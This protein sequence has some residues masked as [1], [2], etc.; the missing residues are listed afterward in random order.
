MAM[1]LKN[2][3]WPWSRSVEKAPVSIPEPDAAVHD[4]AI[5][6]EPLKEI[7][8]GRQAILDEDWAKAAKIWGARALSEP[9]HSRNHRHYIRALIR[10]DR[11][12]EAAAAC[13][14]ARKH[15]R[16]DGEFLLR[17]LWLLDRLGVDD[18]FRKEMQADG[19]AE[20]VAASGRMALI[21]G[22]HFWRRGTLTTARAH[23]LS[24]AA[25]P[26]TQSRAE[27][28]L[29]RLDY[30]AG[31][32]SS[33]KT[34]WTALLND[35]ESRHQPQ[36]PYLF[37]GRIELRNGN[38]EA[39]EELFGIAQ[40]IDPS[41]SA[42]IRKWMPQSAD[43]ALGDL[44]HPQAGEPLPSA[45]TFLLQA[46][47]FAQDPTP[48]I[49]TPRPNEDPD[50]SEVL[51]P[52]PPEP[53]LIDID[54]SIMVA[55]EHLDAQRHDKALDVALGLLDQDDVRPEACEIAGFAA[56]RSG[57]WKNAAFAWGKLAD[58][59]PFRVGALFQAAS[60]CEQLKNR[61]AALEYGERVLRLEPANDKALAFCA[62]QHA[63]SG[64]LAG[65]RA[66]SDRIERLN[67]ENLPDRLAVTLADGFSALGARSEAAT[68][69]DRAMDTDA[70]SAQVALRKARLLYGEGS[71]QRAEE[72]WRELL[73]AP[74]SVV[75]P[76]EPHVF[77]ARC[78]MR[79]GDVDTSI[80]HF[81]EAIRLNPRHME[82]R[83]GLINALLK[84]GDPLAAD[85]ENDDFAR[86]FP[87]EA[88]P[89]ITSLMIG[90]RYQD[91]PVIEARY[92]T[93]L[94]ALEGNL[95][96]L[97]GL[98][99]VIT[100]QRDEARSLAHWAL[101]AEQFPENPD[102]L[103]RLLMQQFVVGQDDRAAL[104]TAEA[105]L[106]HAPDHESGLFHLASLKHR[107]GENDEADRVFQRGMELYPANIGFWVGHASALMRADKVANARALLDR[108]TTFTDD[109]DPVALAD[110][111]RL[112]EITDLPEAAEGFFERALK[113]A[114]ANLQTWRRAVRFNLSR[115][116]YGKAWDMAL[117]GRKLD[118]NDNIISSALAQTSAALQ[119]LRPG[120]DRDET[121]SYRDCLIPDD[122]FGV[123]AR[124]T[125]PRP[126]VPAGTERRG[127]MHI[128]S[129]LGSGGSERQVMFSM[130]ALARV[131]HGM[132]DIS[133]VA[134]SLNPD[135]AQDFFLPLVQRSGFP[136][137][138]LDERELM[139]AVRDMGTAI[140]PHRE[141]VRVAAA[142]PQEIQAMALP[143]LGVFLKNRPEV[144]HTWQDT[145]NIAGAL[146]ALLAGVPRIVM[147]TRSTRP[148]ARRRMR[149]YLEPGYHA[150]LDLPQITMVNNSHNGARDYEDWLSLPK[151]S[152]GVIHNGFDVD[153][154]RAATSHVQ[155]EDTPASL[156]IPEG[157][158]VIGGVMRFSEE[159][160]P[161][162]FVDAAI[163]L[164][165]RLPE[166]HFLLVGEGP[167][168]TELRAKVEAA[169]L[170]GR[171]HMP[172]AKRP[173]EPW[174]SRMS[175]LVLTSRME[176]LPN[177]LIEA[178]ILG[179][180]VAA[181]KVGGVPETMIADQTGVMVDSADPE[182]LADHLYSMASDPARLQTMGLA[183]R[184]WA[185]GNFSLEGMIRNTLGHYKIPDT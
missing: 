30:R 59:Q 136:V 84:S 77:L 72:L 85:R 83:D 4:S 151:G 181:T 179:V 42:R 149:R 5:V 37:L 135:H 105:L 39:A 128:T 56:N 116:A 146:A 7:D 150:L 67:L 152:V 134:R 23:F 145:V 19:V 43:I 103:H 140:L 31:D 172:G 20:A 46:D 176:G 161:E 2:R 9:E 158:Q 50:Q 96:G 10:L 112:A 118:R 131:D 129:T 82:S 1:S 65:L 157:A 177:V 90:Y 33:A 63:R 180:P 55:R 25:D 113:I 15:H 71:F 141:A 14:I 52:D 70:P 175:I 34:R 75:R 171:I 47:V 168:R 35:P 155:D 24:A 88:A 101:L 36:E 139:D 92:A 74:E 86:A 164:A 122:L 11:L 109:D 12:Y 73:E 144:V 143:L 64:N 6:E 111:A 160:R 17:R 48:V 95:I 61:E 130:Q 184:E 185:E 163:A 102:V 91:P 174:M 138:N 142:M 60:A 165:P 89:I 69:I 125:W 178:Q 53:E 13:D 41:T 54:Q 80:S 58:L 18:A 114:P 133:L 94:Q 100:S 76:F 110:L 119:L 106:S 93:A 115:G 99:R 132:D 79:L 126:V 124:K 29:A 117:E 68:W 32:M 127:A 121:V 97:V 21:A 8:A 3:F 49:D 147:G 148:D 154:I 159:K 16:N 153:A 166:T 98:G 38:L 40:Q 170:S 51:A 108:A 44:A 87:N 156:G 182:V 62:R 167:L 104:S 120:W 123:I 22:R 78:A 169:G 183:A 28:H 27:L 66:F 81:R 26:E 162:L 45:D 57:D 107:L 173:V 137:I